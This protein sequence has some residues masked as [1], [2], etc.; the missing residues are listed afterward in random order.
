MTT[1]AFHSGPV[2]KTELK[3][4]YISPSCGIGHGVNCD[5]KD[6]FDSIEEAEKIIESEYEDSVEYTILPYFYT[7]RRSDIA[8]FNVVL[9]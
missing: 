7:E 3:N 9:S 8:E 2:Y 1:E 4:A 6:Y 5:C